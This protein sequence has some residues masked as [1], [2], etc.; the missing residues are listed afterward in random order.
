MT[1]GRVAWG[2]LPLATFLFQCVFWPA[3]IM[4]YRVFRDAHATMQT[5]LEGIRTHLATL[6]GDVRELKTWRGEHQ[7]D[8]DRMH[9]ELIR[10]RDVVLERVTER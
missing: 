5:T 4:G 1:I 6:N 10:L 9:G 7:R 2:W 8:D 3:A